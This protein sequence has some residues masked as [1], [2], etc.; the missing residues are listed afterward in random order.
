MIR[1]LRRS[2]IGATIRQ[3]P[4][5]RAEKFEN[6]RDCTCTPHELVE[7]VVCD[8]C[9]GMRRGSGIG[10]AGGQLPAA[11]AAKWGQAIRPPV[12][13]VF[14]SAKTANEIEQRRLQY[15]PYPPTLPNFLTLPNIPSR[16]MCNYFSV[17]DIRSFEWEPS[18]CLPTRLA[19][20]GPSTF[21]SPVNWTDR[22]THVRRRSYEVPLA[23]PMRGSRTVGQRFARGQGGWQD[24]SLGYVRQVGWNGRLAAKPP[25]R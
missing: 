5:Q 11:P 12:H 8:R 20:A 23:C 21:G 14:G 7:V 15:S 9:Q 18:I 22:C 19:N 6:H 1:A 13:R 25:R 24:A 16:A 10:T 4:H 2:T 3:G 17:T